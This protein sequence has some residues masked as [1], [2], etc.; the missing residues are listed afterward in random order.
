[1]ALEQ[2]LNVLSDYHRPIRNAD[3]M[4]LSGITPEDLGALTE[5]WTDIDAE[6][7]ENI[8]GRLIEISENNLDADFNDLFRFCL[9]DNSPEVKARAIEGLWE[10]DDRRLVAPLIKLLEYDPSDNVRAS[11][12]MGLGKFVVLSQSGKMLSKDGG[13]IK[14]SLLQVIDSAEESGVVKRRA[15]EALAPFNT[16]EVRE[17]IQ[18]IY[19]SDDMEMRCSAVYAMGKSCDPQWLPVILLELRNPN[20][21]M[22]YEASNACGELGEEPAVPHLMPLFDDDDYQT[23]QSAI[24][25]VGAIGGSLARKALL[26]CLKSSDDSAVDAA[27]EALDNLRDGDESLGFGSDI[28]PHSPRS[29]R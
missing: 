18:E 10:C 22:R 25:A 6:R 29:A 4:A 12:A 14:E 26:R 21:A 2:Y 28:Y 24:S 16:T 19:E 8:L 20:P 23:Q 27:Q 11:A 9:S 13:R 15:I 7:R 1:M 3:L 17:I 5:V